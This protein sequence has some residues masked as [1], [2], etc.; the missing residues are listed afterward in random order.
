MLR[1]AGGAG[2]AILLVALAPRP[3]GA[4]CDASVKP[5]PGAVGYQKRPYACEGMYIGLQSAPVGVQVI[6]LVR[7]TLDDITKDERSD[8]VVYIKVRHK[9]PRLDPEVRV[10]GRPRQANL[11]WAL[12]GTVRVGSYI[13]WNLGT[14]VKPM[15]LDSAK[16]G[17]YG[18]AKLHGA[19]GTLGGPVFVPLEVTRDSG[20]T[21]ADEM[22]LIVRIPMAS[23]LCWSLAEGK[24][25]QKF[26]MTPSCVRK[27]PPINSDGYFRI[28]IPKQPPGERALAIRWRPRGAANFGDPV[29]LSI[30]FW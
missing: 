8:S 7:G 10:I 23:E 11:H 25:A 13:R 19:D 5:A 24:A 6:S 26:A 17:I 30:H 15:E 22:E 20:D 27:V 2:L 3:A 28:E 16:I 1:A 18:L 12:D 14:V 21:G 4:Q 9:G 29:H